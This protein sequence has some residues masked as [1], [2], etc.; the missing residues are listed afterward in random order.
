MWDGELTA[1]RY[2]AETGTHLII[3]VDSTHRGPAAGGTRASL[4]P[5]FA[6]ALI[7][8][9]RLASAMT[10]K[11]AICRLPM[12]G[13]KSVLSLPAPR[14]EL[15]D[16]VWKRILRLHAE[17]IEKL[18]GTY[19]TGPDVNTDSR[20]MDA[21]SETTRYAFGRSEDRGGAGSSANATAR[22]VF[23]AMRVTAQRLGHHSLSG[24]RVLVQG[25]GA[26]GSGLAALARDAGA[27]VLV[28]DQ[29]PRRLSSASDDGYQVIDAAHA[30]AVSCDIFAPCALGGVIDA[31]VARMLPAAAVVGAANNV[32]TDEH[33]SEILMDRRVLYAPD[34]A[35]N[36]GGALHLV[37]REVLGWS[38]DVVDEHIVGIGDTIGQIFDLSADARLTPDAAART[39]ARERLRAT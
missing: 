16:A 18:A 39:I 20:D 37:G 22:G 28:C 19:W 35:A 12:G 10:L 21:L 24:R 14:H 1:S 33:A 31:A 29:D 9:G 36:G 27:I 15:P 6:E 7:D 38:D 23:E 4:Y 13:G 34:F 2:D 32:L 25:M 8:A 30:T 3:R 17:N 11:M 26:V 5:G